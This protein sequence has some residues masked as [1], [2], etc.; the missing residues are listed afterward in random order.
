[1]SLAVKRKIE[2]E[3]VAYLDKKLKDNV[4]YLA[5]VK[6]KLPRIVM[7]EAARVCVGIVEATGRNDG[8]M[9]ELFQE[10]VG[11]HSREYWCLS[12]AQS[13][14]AYAELK[15][16]VKSP[17]IATE[18]TITL[19]ES[20]PDEYK[21]KH[22]PLPGALPIWRNGS[23]W[24]GHVEIL[25]AADETKFS[26]V[27]GNTS[28]TVK[29]GAVNRNGNGVFYTS[30]SRAAGPHSRRLLGFIIPFPESKPAAKKA[31]K[32]KSAKRKSAKRKSAKRKAA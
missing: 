13:M 19:W 16:G 9:V 27:G 23:A 31:T 5:A 32:R 11:G 30:R 4:I 21:V 14:I 17:L 3:L 28:G 12:F 26:A 7:V 15:T 29:P 2:P 10:T 8:P 18:S 20:T 24:T 1:M 6:A 22:T 25:I